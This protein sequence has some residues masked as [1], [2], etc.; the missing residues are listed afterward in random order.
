M[1]DTYD[2]QGEYTNQQIWDWLENYCEKNPDKKLVDATV[3]LVQAL[4]PK[5]T[6]EEPA[7]K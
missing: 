2:I 7:K 3:I 1:P 5:R 4:H 6:Q